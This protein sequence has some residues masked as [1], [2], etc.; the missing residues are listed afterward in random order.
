MRTFEVKILLRMFLAIIIGV[1][2]LWVASRL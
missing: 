2:L 1:I